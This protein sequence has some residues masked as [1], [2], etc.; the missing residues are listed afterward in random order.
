VG[1][2][3]LYVRD[4]L[5]AAFDRVVD[6]GWFVLGPEVEAFE[7]SFATV[8]GARHCVGVNS[9]LDAIE[10]ILRA[11]GVG[12]GDEV[13][14]P[15]HTFVATWL[16]VTLA[17]ATPVPVAVREDTYNLDPARIEAAI[18]PRTR[19]VMPVH[20][21][22]QPA[23]MDA[24][25]AV[26]RAHGLAVVE[27]AAQAHGALL[28]GRPAG[29]L[30]DAAAFSFYPGKNLG[31]LG[32]GGAIVTG[33]ED[34]AA[35]CRALRNYGSPRKYEHDVQGR[36]SRLDELQA[37]LLRVKVKR[38]ADW[39]ARRRAVAAQYL[40]G[41]RDVPVTL[42]VVRDDAEPVWHLFVIRHGD[43][44]ALQERLTARGIGTLIHYPQP[45][46]RS[47]A[48]AGLTVDPGQVAVAERLSAEVLSLPMGPHLG[49]E[50]TAEVVAAVRAAASVS[51]S[52]AR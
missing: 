7:A 37:A 49:P 45:A 5:R 36:N 11:L 6:S 2:P 44:D 1:V 20:L 31:A 28:G 21:Y 48:Y 42:P 34:L 16:G 15:A 22:G 39:N 8:C 29:G 27:D 26:A 30:G 14:V 3:F 12:E 10:L 24:I 50:A 9:G 41:L 40:D 51:A 43:R 18:T 25:T 35:R 46:H 47:G 4:E 23:D 17:G 13:I 33:D 32:D 19:A 52:A 38:L